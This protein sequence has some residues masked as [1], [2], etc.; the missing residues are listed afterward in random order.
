ADTK[1]DDATLWAVA[2][3]DNPTGMPVATLEGFDKAINAGR[4]EVAARLITDVTVRPTHRRRGLLRRMMGAELAETHRRGVPVAALTVTEATIYGR[5][6]FGVS[7][8]GHRIE[9]D[10][11]ER[12]GL[13]SAGS[14]RV[15]L[16]APADAIDTLN[17]VFGRFHAATRGSVSLPAFYQ[18][19]LSGAWDDEA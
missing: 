12:F 11:A 10:S 5:F 7:T 14:G 2:D 8:R 19:M 9:V 15:Q 16:I 6:G 17:E 4:A 3:P 18:D 1:A 13:L